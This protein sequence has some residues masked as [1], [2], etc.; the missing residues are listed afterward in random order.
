MDKFL[1][2]KWNKIWYFSNGYS[3]YV[4]LDGLRQ[5]FIKTFHLHQCLKR[6]PQIMWLRKLRLLKCIWF[7]YVNRNSKWDCI[8]C[9]SVLILKLPFFL[10]PFELL[11]F[12]LFSGF[13]SSSHD[14]SSFNATEFP[15]SSSSSSNSRLFRNKIS[16][17]KQVIA[18]LVSTWWTILG[19]FNFP[20]G[21]VF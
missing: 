8:S 7:L 21:Q 12:F 16:Q 14:D 10:S 4:G 13:P 19:F 2:Q 9:Q 20:I 11:S 18:R 6:Y 1:C 17:G 15:P 3:K 5:D